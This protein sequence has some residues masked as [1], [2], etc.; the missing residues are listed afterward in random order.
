VFNA[1]NTA[2][3]AVEEI[4]AAGSHD[5]GPKAERIEDPSEWTKEKIV[6]R[7]KTIQGSGGPEG[8]FDD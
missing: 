1:E 8:D 3:L 2:P 4:L 7:A 6:A 5:P